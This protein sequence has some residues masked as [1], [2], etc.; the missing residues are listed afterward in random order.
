MKNT[1]CAF[2]RSFWA[3][4]IDL[5]VSI[6]FYWW[7][8]HQFICLCPSTVT[9]L[10]AGFIVQSIL[11]DLRLFTY[12]ECV[13]AIV[14]NCSSY[15]VSHWPAVGGVT[16]QSR[17]R[18]LAFAPLSSAFNKGFPSVCSLICGNDSFMDSDLCGIKPRCRLFVDIVWDFLF[19]LPLMFYFG[20]MNRNVLGVFFAW[21]KVI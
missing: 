7:Y 12:D 13:H 14:S 1:F 5:S 18:S 8:H 11:S 20:C 3:R 2:N 9:A 19:W 17:F 10:R 6:T 16:G 21:N 4:F 15:V